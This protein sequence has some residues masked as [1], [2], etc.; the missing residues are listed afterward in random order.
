MTCSIFLFIYQLIM[1]NILKMFSFEKLKNNVRDVIIRFPIS[2]I[3]IVINSL[4]FV[5]LINFDP[6][7]V[8][9]DYVIRSIFSIIVIFFLSVWVYLFSESVWHSKLKTNIS[10]LFVIFFWILFFINFDQ[11]IDYFENFVFFLLTL[12]W[13]LT[14][15]FFA[16]YLKIMLTQKYKENVFYS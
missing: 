15:L 2:F 5:V 10:Q 14:F 11:D 7:N 6:S 3:F 8:I 13:I 12:I 9:E 16:P 1:K 4:L